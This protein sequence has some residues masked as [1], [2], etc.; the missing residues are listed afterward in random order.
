[1]DDSDAESRRNGHTTPEF[2]DL[3]DEPPLLSGQIR[4]Q[5]VSDDKP[6]M[7]TARW[8]LMNSIKD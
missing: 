3:Y 1:M 8:K 6:F 5:F 2:G 4:G 7:S